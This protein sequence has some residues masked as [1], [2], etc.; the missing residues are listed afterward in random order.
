[1]TT[2]LWRDFGGTGAELMGFSFS[3]NMS[4][5]YDINKIML[6]KYE[7]LILIACFR[8]GEKVLVHDN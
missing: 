2:S 6:D 8:K 4:L 5:V 1:L 7:F 3:L